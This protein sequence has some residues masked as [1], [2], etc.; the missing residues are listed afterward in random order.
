[1]GRKRKIEL[2]LSNST[3]EAHVFEGAGHAW[4]VDRPREKTA[5]P[6]VRGCEVVYNATGQASVNGTPYTPVPLSASRLE[7]TASRAR[8]QEV[9]QSCARYDGY[10]VGRD[11]KTRA[12]ADRAFYAFLNRVLYPAPVPEPS[13]SPAPEEGAES[14]GENAESPVPA[15]P[16]A[17]GEGA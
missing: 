3:V 9:L 13:P 2:P 14:V 4:E 8:G 15:V 6:Y 1:M 10:L 5:N 7:R 16:A 17:V 11:D 12:K